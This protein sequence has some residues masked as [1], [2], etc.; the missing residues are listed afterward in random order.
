MSTRVHESGVIHQSI[1]R[2]WEV[3]RP[4]DLSFLNAVARTEL[5][6]GASSSKVGGVRRVTYRDGTIQ[7]VKLVE[8]S[9]AEHSLTYDVIESTPP[10][11]YLSAIHT[12][13]LRRITSVNHTLVECTSDYSKDATTT[14]ILD[15]KFK[16]L[17]LIKQLAKA[18]ESK[19]SKFFRQLNFAKLDRLTSDQVDAAWRLF[20]RDGNGVLDKREISEVIEG[21]L[22]RLA[23]EQAGIVSALSNMFA[24]ADDKEIKAE[25]VTEI[26]FADLTRRKEGLA[27]ELAGKLDVNRD[28]KVD[29]A[30]FKLLFAQWLEDKITEGIAGAL[31]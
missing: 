10:V 6:A 20:D 3:L 12:V 2:V 9:D 13:K 25:D 8:L 29:Y 31:T 19:A 5:E 1:D 22:K 28:G 15:S 7:R 30:E 18:S 23:S 17:D 26:M 4:L 11:S 24:D 14:V 16:K 21:L 27:R